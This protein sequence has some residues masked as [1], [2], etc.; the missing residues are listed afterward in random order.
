MHAVANAATTSVS[1]GN[2]A[3]APAFA[4]ARE[5]CRRHARSFYFASTFL[6]RAKRDAAYAVYAFCRMID[7]AIDEDDDAI[8]RDDG[9]RPTAAAAAG[10]ASAPPDRGPTSGLDSRLAL[11]RNRLDDIYS[12]RVQPPPAAVRSEARLALHA[13]ALTARRYEIPK[14]YFLELAEGCRMDLV[15]S[16]YS[17]WAA[18]EQYCYRV[19]GVVGL[20]M[21]RVFGVTH[22]DASR[23]AV[24]MGN[25]M[26]LTNILRDVKED[27]DR[28][29]LYLPLEDLARFGYGERDLA[30]GVVND[31]FRNLM[32]FQIRRA[33][34]LFRDGAAGLSHVANDGSRL[35][36]A[37]MAVVY[38]GILGAIERQAYDVFAG[39]AHLSTVQKL[40]RLP[41]AWRLA[42][43]PKDQPVPEVF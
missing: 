35:T 7:D 23:Q 19:A 32:R 41:K 17:T 40:R 28:G 34:A 15:I 4:A 2:A 38:A 5:I 9:A 21:C 37:S 18:L 14:A 22:E 43:R 42:R 10:R 31:N 3:D 16:R 13:F 27:W 26:Q 12:D 20:I 1:S 39:R 30:A 36:A 8:E 29:R 25:A 33:R 24:Q 6:P 11:F